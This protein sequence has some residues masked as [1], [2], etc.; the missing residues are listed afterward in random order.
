[1]KSAA[2]KCR[3]FTLVEILVSVSILGI[4]LGT[5]GTAFFQSVSTQR[6][7]VD[8]GY[9]T[10]EA[11]KGLS[12][13]AQDVRMAQHAT[14][15]PDAN[16]LNLSWTDEFNFD[17]NGTPTCHKSSYLLNGDA[18][19]RTYNGTTHT[20][21]RR[22]VSVTFPTP[23][24]GPDPVS[25]V[26][27]DLEVETSPSNTKTVSMT[28]SM[29]SRPKAYDPC[30]VTVIDEATNAAFATVP[31]RQGLERNRINQTTN[32]VHVLN[33]FSNNVSGSDGSSNT[34]IA[35]PSAGLE[36]QRS[37]DNETTDPTDVTN[38]GSD[39]VSGSD[40][41]SNTVIATPSVDLEP[42]RDRD[43]ETTVPTDVT[44]NGSDT[45]SVID[46]SSNTVIATPSVGLEPQRDR[47]NE[48]TDP[49]DVTNNGSDTVSVIDGNTDNED[50]DSV[51]AILD[52][53]KEGRNLSYTIQV[54]NNGPDT[55][56]NVTVSDPLPTGMTLVSTNGCIEDPVGVPTC[57]IGDI[58]PGGS[59]EYNMTVNL[60]EDLGDGSINNTVNVAADNADF[61]QSDNKFG[62]VI[63]VEALEA[64]AVRRGGTTT[65]HTKEPTA[66]RQLAGVDSSYP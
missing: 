28:T 18:L 56:T 38:N 33:R 20:V 47:D 39:A 50:D 44:N 26:T 36:P 31:V 62:V 14:V 64:P 29:M 48:T 57:S 42:Q 37:P 46:A 7:I 40:G 53:V 60:S 59:S 2:P 3:G 16:T 49:T 4:I 8:D 32:K 35:T 24:P 6:L 9:A 30:P 22:V 12:W 1:M 21:A 34:V 23:T 66:D 19:E 65:S 61:N 43:N 13:F 58:P 54:D 25:T 15:D 41:S 45:V 55:A 11:R 17:F 51:S 63:S 52:P 5:L 27:I 10:N